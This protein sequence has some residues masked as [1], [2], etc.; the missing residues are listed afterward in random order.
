MAAWTD[1]Q[2]EPSGR[3]WP[4]ALAHGARTTVTDLLGTILLLAALGMCVVT[5]VLLPP[6]AVVVPGL[7]CLATV[8]VVR[9]TSPEAKAE[10]RAGRRSGRR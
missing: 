6:V 4:G 3:D 5:V 1:G 9:R 8:Q 2:G 7:V 10:R